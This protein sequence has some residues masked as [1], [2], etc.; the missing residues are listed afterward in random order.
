VG[1][2][3]GKGEVATHWGRCTADISGD[4]RFR[5]TAM[6]TLEN[7]G[8]NERIRGWGADDRVAGCL[9]TL[10]KPRLHGRVHGRRSGSLVLVA[11]LA[12]RAAIVL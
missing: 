8:L 7:V 2:L 6:A 9:L 5:T 1:L 10:G 4:V 11:S 3:W 12:G